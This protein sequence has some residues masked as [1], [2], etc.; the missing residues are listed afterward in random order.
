MRIG[1]REYFSLPLI[2][3]LALL[4]LVH[5]YLFRDLSYIEIY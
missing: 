4:D 2:T 5:F 1:G 3:L